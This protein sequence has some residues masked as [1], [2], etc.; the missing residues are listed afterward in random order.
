[1]NLAHAH[2]LLNHFPTIAFG[3]GLGLLVGG[4]YVASD[5]LKRASLVILFMTSV[6]SI[7]V[8]QRE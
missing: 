3:V 7:A 1:M 5:E 4:I 8:S 2:L 6:L